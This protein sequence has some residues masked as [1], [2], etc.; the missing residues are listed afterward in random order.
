M[1]KEYYRGQM[2]RPGAF[3][4]LVN[5]FYFARKGL[6]EVIRELAGQISG[7]ALDVGCGYKPYEK[8]FAVTEYVGLELDTPDNRARKRADVYYDGRTLPFESASFDSI[9]CNQV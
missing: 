1:L 3:G 5:P 2:V 4:L 8:L 7:R 9:I 6:Y